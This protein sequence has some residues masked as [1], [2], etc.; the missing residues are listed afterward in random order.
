MSAISV[1]IL[2]DDQPQ[3]ELMSDWLTEGGYQVFHC[4]SGEGF[5]SRLAHNQPHILILDWQLPDCEGIDILEDLR[6]TL[7]FA[8]PVLFATA[9][10]SEE[11]IVR[12]LNSG[13]DDYLIKPLRKAELLARLSALWRRSAAE[14]PDRLELGPVRLD[15]RNQRAHV[16]DEEVRLTATEFKIVETLSSQPGRVFTRGQLLDA[17]RQPGSCPGQFLLARRQGLLAPVG[18]LPLLADLLGE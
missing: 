4:N 1:G 17:G 18:D 11:D 14:L 10:D 15:V 12:G 6:K 16:G 5:M 2:E 8:G 3:A 13:A 9:K 7:R